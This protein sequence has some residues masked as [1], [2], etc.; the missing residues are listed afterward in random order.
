MSETEYALGVHC[1][2]TFANLKPASLFWLKKE[3][4]GDLE[5]YRR[6]FAKKNFRFVTM[7]EEP[8]RL[9]FYVFRYDALKKVLF[10]EKNKIFLRD[11]G[12]E[13]GSVCGAVVRLREK[14]SEQAAFPHEIGIFLGYPLEDV[15]GFIGNAKGS[16]LAGYWKVYGEPEKKAKLFT[17][18]K[19]CSECICGKLMQGRPLTSIFNLS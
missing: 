3:N 7:K 14:M 17:R 16:C 15:C 4:N 2:V 11:R 18:Y 6:C 19:K 9:L 8:G 5:Y 13:Y 10:E 12:Y 1:G